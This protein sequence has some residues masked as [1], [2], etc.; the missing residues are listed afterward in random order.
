MFICEHC[1]FSTVA[2]VAYSYLVTYSFVV[3]ANITALLNT[4][5][6]VEPRYA[7]MLSAVFKQRFWN[8]VFFQVS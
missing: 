5:I 7:V 2:L 8:I 3:A 1:C 4:A 6:D